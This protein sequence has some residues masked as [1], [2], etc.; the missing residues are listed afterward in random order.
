[1][2]IENPSVYF[3]KRIRVT[4]KEDETI[5]KLDGYNYDFDDDGNE[6]L[7]MEIACEDGL[8]YGFAENEIESIEVLNG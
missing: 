1:M 7:E 3:G 5:G 4:T 2:K 6:Y 8:L